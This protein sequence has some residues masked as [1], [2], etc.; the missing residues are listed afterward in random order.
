MLI[1]A[2]DEVDCYCIEREVSDDDIAALTELGAISRLSLSNIACLTVVQAKRLK[3]LK[4]VKSMWLWCDVTR[5]AMR[6]IIGIPDLVTIDVMS[7][8]LGGK[9]AHFDRAHSLETFRANLFLTEADIFA[10]AKCRSM[11]TLGLQNSAITMAAI[12]ALLALP[13]LRAL[14]IEATRF[15]DKMARRLSASNTITALDVGATRI[16][17]KGLKHIVKMQQLTHLDLWATT[18]NEDDLELLT[19]L[20]RLEYLS[21]GTYDHGVPLN[22]ERVTTLLLRMPTLRNVW[23]DGVMLSPVQLAQLSA[24]KIVLRV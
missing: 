3:R 19:V 22:A 18:L 7:M 14:D 20:P 17:R 1:A 12:K 15:D 11:Q 9:L 10:V 21:I 4:S 5:S 8:P 16:T 13:K 6:E 23:L 24:N 2:P